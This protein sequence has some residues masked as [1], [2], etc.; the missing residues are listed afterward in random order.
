M[1][2][3]PAVTP[4]RAVYLIVEMAA[5][6]LAA[7]IALYVLVFEH[8]IPLFQVFPPVLL[9]I[10][11][12]LTLDPSHS[13]RRTLFTFFGFKTLASILLL[14]AVMGGGLAWYASEYYPDRF[15][16]FPRRA[17]DLYVDIMIKYCLYSV[18]VQELIYRVLFFHRYAPLFGGRVW[19]AVLVSAVLFSLAHAFFPNWEGAMLISLV[20]GLIFAARYA[21][22]RSF[23]AVVI[24]HSLYGM[25]IFAIGFGRFFFTGVSN[26]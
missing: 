12:L 3:A 23:W 8:R 19:P 7:P 14:F 13:W 22:T 4:L 2:A 17:P 25:L 16:S 20:G 26:I 21:T 5:L 6:Y 1:T 9:L 18:P 24:E 11:V 15:L 10:A